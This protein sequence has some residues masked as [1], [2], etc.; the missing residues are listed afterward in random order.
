MNKAEQAYSASEAEMLALVWA[1]KYFPCYLYGKEFSVRTDRAALFYLRNFA[2]NNSRLMR[3]SLRLPEF[4][5][6]VEH[7]SGSKI[8][9]V[10]AL[11]RHVGVIMEGG[12]PSKER[13]LREQ[14]K[15]SFC[16]AQKPKTQCSK[17]EY[18]F[19]LR[20]CHV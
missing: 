2:D 12:L 10:D 7:K 9:H 14:G 16:S 1:T 17:S 6:I 19:R 4:D 11:S 3:W 15:D 20:W 5:F 13:I 8:S 18:F